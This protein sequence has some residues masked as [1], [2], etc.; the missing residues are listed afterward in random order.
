ML[1]NNRYF[2]R[3]NNQRVLEQT[4]YG[5]VQYF[6]VALFECY[7]EEDFGPAKTLMNMCFT[8]YFEGEWVPPS[9][10]TVAM[11]ILDWLSASVHQILTSSN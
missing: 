2:Q 1:Y 10:A 4:F 3:V 9:M 7:E 6:A 5:L 8:F 11:G